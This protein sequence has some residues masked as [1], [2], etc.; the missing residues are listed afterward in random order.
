MNAYDGGGT[1]RKAIVFGFSALLLLA[2]CGSS[3]KHGSGGSGASTAA[4]VQLSGTVTNKG[5][6]T[7]SGGSI[8]IDAKDL[9]FSPTFVKAPAGSTLN[10]TIKNEGTNQHTFT[11]DGANIDKSLAPGQSTTV[12]VKVPASGSVNFYCR[13]HRGVGMQGA[14]V[15]S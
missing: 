14:I 1:M 12:S 2:A 10:V 8:E 15:A 13:F 6:A 3:S 7:A 11:I 9:Y 4:P 5:V